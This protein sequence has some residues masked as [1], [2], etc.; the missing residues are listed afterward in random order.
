M[1]EIGGIMDSI[2]GIA[3]MVR[4]FENIKLT[5]TA[6]RLFRDLKF[7]LEERKM[8][9]K[10]YVEGAEPITFANTVTRFSLGDSVKF[11]G[12]EYEIYEFYQSAHAQKNVVDWLLLRRRVNG[13]VFWANVNPSEVILVSH[14]IPSTGGNLGN[15]TEFPNE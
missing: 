2:R 8:E 10:T 3:D 6:T 4:T 9:H 12:K 7:L 13:T 14:P 11:N 1:P 15:F 5:T